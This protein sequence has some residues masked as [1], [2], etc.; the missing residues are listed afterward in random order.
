MMDYSLLIAIEKS[1]VKQSERTDQEKQMDILDESEVFRYD[2]NARKLDTPSISQ[3]YR[4]LGV[5]KS[6]TQRP[7]RREIQMINQ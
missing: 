5:A 4:K 6:N 3:L 7:Q 1:E 2:T